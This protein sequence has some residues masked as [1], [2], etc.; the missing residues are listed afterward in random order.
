MSDYSR[1]CRGWRDDRD[2]NTFCRADAFAATFLRSKT[3]SG[4][5][6]GA[7]TDACLTQR[8]AVSASLPTDD[9]PQRRVMHPE[10]AQRQRKWR[11]NICREGYSLFRIDRLELNRII[12]VLPPTRRAAAVEVLLDVVP[13]ELANLKTSTVSDGPSSAR[14]TTAH[15]VTARAWLEVEIG[16]VHLL[17]AERAFRVLL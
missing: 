9:A 7:P 6:H 5:Q 10:H 17:K 3:W 16:Y 4:R 11:K 12:S 13:A 14:R 15:L 2:A 8:Q 1:E